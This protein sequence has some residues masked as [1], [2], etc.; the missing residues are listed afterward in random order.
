MTIDLLLLIGLTITALGAVMKRDTVKAAIALA[1]SSI[2]VA[3]LLFRLLSPLAAVFELSVCAGL[4]TV[5]FMSTISLTK[6]LTR[7][8]E[9]DRLHTRARHLAVL[10]VLVAAAGALIAFVGIPM[11]FTLP[12][13]APPADVRAVMWNERQIDLVGQVLV[14]LAGFFGVLVLFKERLRATRKTQAAQV[15][16]PVEVSVI[17]EANKNG[18]TLQ[19]ERDVTHEPVLR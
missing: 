19:A 7:P 12:Q 17:P 5:I 9:E 13:S 2:I 18:A 15:P 10:P 14:I 1:L 8:E 6:P 11:T 16:Q 4:I 3:I